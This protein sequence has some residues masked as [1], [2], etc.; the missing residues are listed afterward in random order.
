[1]NIYLPKGEYVIADPCHV[2]SDDLYI[3]I[4]L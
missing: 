1:M 2:L 4:K 3:I